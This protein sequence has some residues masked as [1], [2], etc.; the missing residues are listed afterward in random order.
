MASKTL[1][2]VVYKIALGCIA[3]RIEPF[4]DKI[5]NKDQTQRKVYRNKYQYENSI[6]FSQLA[7]D[8]SVIF[9]SSLKDVGSCFEKSLIFFKVF[10]L[11]TLNSDC[12]CFVWF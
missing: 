12:F 10:F 6:F 5:I 11:S 1:L 9:E 2:N 7:D 4:F 3:K 8:T